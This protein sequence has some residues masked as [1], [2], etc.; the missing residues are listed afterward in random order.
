MT[1]IL[2]KANGAEPF[3]WGDDNLA[4]PGE[5]RDSYIAALRAADDHVHEP[6]LNF[7]RSGHSA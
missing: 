5:V 6:L 1:D 2:L 4:A 3:H 7:V